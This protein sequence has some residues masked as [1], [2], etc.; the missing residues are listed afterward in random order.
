MTQRHALLDQLSELKLSAMARAFEEQL[1]DAE[2]SELSFEERLGLLLDRESTERA[3]RR[4]TLRLRQAKLRYPQASF[5]DLDLRAKRGLNRALMVKLRACDWISDRLNLLVTGETGTGKTFLGCAM[6]HQA[7]R[8]GHTVIY[9][10]LPQLFRELTISRGDGSHRLLLQR[11]QRTHLLLLDDWGLHPFG[12]TER[13]DLYEILEDRF[14]L[15]STM[16]ISQLPV[17]S[18]YQVLGD[19]T[20]A[21]AILDRLIHAAYRIDLKGPSKRKERA[22]AALGGSATEE[23]T[24]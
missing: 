5:E 15:R 19:P 17:D 16:V 22:R 1:E 3:A 20:L 24:K 14:D 12:D 13:R 4:L 2:I 21:D 18:W 6:A 23:V 8:E 9:R 7:C 11:L 10:R